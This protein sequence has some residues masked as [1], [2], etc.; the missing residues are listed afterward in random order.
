MRVEEAP[1]R[2]LP[3]LAQGLEI[4]VIGL[5]RAAR[6][7]GFADVLHHDAM[8]PQSAEF[9]L[10]H[11]SWQAPFIDEAID[12]CHPAQLGKE[13]GIE[14]DLV[15]AAGDLALARRHLAPLARIDLH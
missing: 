11:S 5:E 13:R 14:A 15:H 10:P 3:K 6:A 9:T 7:E 8:Q 12:E 4:L 2:A 1:R